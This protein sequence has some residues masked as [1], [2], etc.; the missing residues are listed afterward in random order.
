MVLCKIMRNARDEIN[1]LFNGKYGLKFG[2]D[3]EVLAIK[4]ISEANAKGSI[5]A[6]RDVMKANPKI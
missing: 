6:L 5:V 4:E 3:T 2:S 1:Q